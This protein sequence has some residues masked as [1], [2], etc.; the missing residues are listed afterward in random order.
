LSGC[1]Y[2]KGYQERVAYGRYQEALGAGNL[3]QARF[4]LMKLV[5]IDQDVANYWLEL[6]RLQLQMGDYRGAYDAL[7]HAH[8]LDRSNV[9]VLST[10]AEMA[11]LS[12]DIDL[13]SEHAQ[14]LA[15]MAPN[16]PVVTMVRGYVAFKSGELDKADAAADAVLVSAP[17]EP[18]AKILKSKILIA[19]DRVDDALA[20]LEEQ[21]RAVPQ[22]RRTTTALTE[23]YRAR[24]DW[25]NLARIQLDA[26]RLDPNDSKTSLSAIEALLRSG[27][28]SG[29]RQVSAPLLSPAANPQF[30]DAV[31]QLWA[32][33]APRGTSLPGGLDLANAAA[34]DRRTAFASYYNQIVKPAA[35]AA[36]LGGSRLPVTHVNARWNAVYAQSL[37]LEGRGEEAKRLFDLVLDR[38]PDQVEALR[39][40]SALE[41]RAGLTKQAIIDA[42]RLITISPRSGEDRLL[43]AQAYLAAG[44]RNEVRRTLWQAFQD[45]P[46]NDRVVSAL[47]SVLASSGDAQGERR[48]EDES[49]DRRMAKLMKDVV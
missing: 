7:T 19:K 24:G 6:A 46:E 14:T 22:D 45:L 47:R 11:L 37:A 9:E 8:E 13:A 15:L 43:L 1:S 42:Q 20:L 49:H 3:V 48:L 5:S 25:R 16:S 23:L 18:F 29:A 41:A 10:M 2:V 35:A 28:V 32:N 27:N 44:N 26:H 30:L 4:A 17:T 36:L 21:H 40:R 39:G 34:G 38:E 31:L 33:A 12:G